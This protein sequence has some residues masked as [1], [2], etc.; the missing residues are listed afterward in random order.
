MGLSG[1][2]IRIA[3]RDK[4]PPEVEALEEQEKKTETT[5][6]SEGALNAET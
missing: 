5:Q 6:S 2:K 1:V 3:A 4:I